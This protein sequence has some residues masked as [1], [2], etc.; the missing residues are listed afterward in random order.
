MRVE[1]YFLPKAC[2]QSMPALRL[3]RSNCTGRVLIRVLALIFGL[4]PRRLAQKFP[5]EMSMSSSTAH[6][7]SRTKQISRFARF[8]RSTFISAQCSFFELCQL[9]FHGTCGASR[10]FVRS[11]ALL[12]VAGASHRT[13]LH[14]HGRHRIFCTLLQRWQMLVDMRGGC[15]CHLSSQYFLQVDL[16]F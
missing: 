8:A 15:R 14:S 5:C 12:C 10:T 3:S 1:C 11:E 7:R 2:P 4:C 9:I 6:A 13:L 16:K